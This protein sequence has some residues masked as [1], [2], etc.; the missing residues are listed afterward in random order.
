MVPGLAVDGREAGEFF[1]LVG[2]ERYE[3][4]LALLRDDEQQRLIRQQQHLAG[5]V[6]ATLPL[7]LA[8]RE[9]QAIE[10]VAVETS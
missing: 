1:V 8:R 6:A 10:D 2:V 3:H 7:P 5:T 4:Q 9:V